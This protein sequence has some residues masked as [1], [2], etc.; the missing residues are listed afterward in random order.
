MLLTAGKLAGIALRQ[1][2]QAHQLKQLVGARLAGFLLLAA[3][4]KRERDVAQHRAL[5]EQAEVL[6]DH[7]HLRAQLK[8][9]LA[10]QVRDVAAVVDD[11]A[12]RGALEQVEAAHERGL[13]RARRADDAEHVAIVYGEV[14]VA[15]RMVGAFALAIRLAHVLQLNHVTSDRSDEYHRAPALIEH[16]RNLV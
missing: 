15:Q 2:G 7:A 14:H 11:G 13:A 8:Q 9:R 3:Q 16:G 5:L 1:V 12:F 6:E 10:R 4:L